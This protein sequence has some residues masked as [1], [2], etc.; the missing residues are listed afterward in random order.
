MSKVR[1][2]EIDLS[3]IQMSEYYSDSQ[4]E[5]VKTSGDRNSLSKTLIMLQDELL[6][7]TNRFWKSFFKLSSFDE[8]IYNVFTPNEVLKKLYYLF[9]NITYRLCI[10]DDKVVSI[11]ESDKSYLDHSRVIETLSSLR[12]A[13]LEWG[14]GFIRA[15]FW[16][17]N[18]EQ[19]NEDLLTEGM[20]LT[21]PF[22][23]ISVPFIH[24][25]L[26]WNKENIKLNYENTEFSTSINIQT[27]NPYE[28]LRL[29]VDSLENVHGTGLL[30]ALV[31]ELAKKSGSKKEAS[32]LRSKMSELNLIEEASIIKDFHSPYQ[33]L[34]F[35][36]EIRAKKESHSEKIQKYIDKSISKVRSQIAFDL[37]Q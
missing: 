28:S 12:P 24:E 36:C 2:V 31:K 9:P 17:P 11:V 32:S 19:I 27:H 30:S 15:Y 26:K 20:C 37:Y 34:K 5:I 13:D 21:I 6:L 8:K 14:E 4:G 35:C 22:D 1:Y 29:K 7:T 23:G 10:Q 18:Q 16:G 25:S 3:E 33:L